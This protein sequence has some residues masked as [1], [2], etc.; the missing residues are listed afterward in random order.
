MSFVAPR[1]NLV[2][3]VLYKSKGLYGGAEKDWEQYKESTVV[4]EHGYG[5]IKDVGDRY[6][7]P[8]SEFIS[9][10]PF[11][12]ADE[13]K[14]VVLLRI[15]EKDDWIEIEE[16]PFTLGGVGDEFTISN[17]YDWDY[18]CGIRIVD[19]PT[20]H[21]YPAVCFALRPTIINTFKI[22]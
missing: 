21:T 2:L 3:S 6:V 13:G 12:K 1:K 10:S 19:D 7:I 11:T 18:D 22:Y 14:K 16:V 9:I 8:A 17:V 5:H 20:K 4:Y 15:P